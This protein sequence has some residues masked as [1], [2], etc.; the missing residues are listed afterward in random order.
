MKFYAEFTEHFETTA[1]LW[2]IIQRQG[3]NLTDTGEKVF[4][5]GDVSCYE[6]GWIL[7]QCAKFG[8]V[9]VSIPRNQLPCYR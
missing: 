5:Y 4:L 9:K 2:F 7:D 3:L 1:A 6:L 8:E